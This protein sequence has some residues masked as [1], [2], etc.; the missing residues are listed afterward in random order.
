MAIDTDQNQGSSYTTFKVL[1]ATS[2]AY[3]SAARESA[4][5]ISACTYIRRVSM[6]T[7]DRLAFGTITTR[8]GG[9][10]NLRNADITIS[11]EIF[12][13]TW[14]MHMLSVLLSI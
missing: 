11:R 8:I 9:I 2:F 1:P 10:P 5:G 6:P 4:A 14:G 3:S 12:E 13:N 7:D